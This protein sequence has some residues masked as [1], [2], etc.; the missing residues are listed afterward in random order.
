MNPGKG[1][2]SMPVKPIPDGYHS[3]TP[4]LHAKGVPRLIEFLKAAFGAIELMTVYH[5]DG[6]VMHAEVKIGDSIVMLDEAMEG[7][8][9][10]S[11]SFYLYV[12]DADATYRAA[13]DAGGES[14]M[15]PS[16]QFWGDRFSAIKDPA[17]NTW[18]VATHVEDVDAEELARRARARK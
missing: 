6:G 14:F 5:Q 15:E 16:D 13:L 1:G 2:I 4:F 10:S 8:S 17:G 3:I 18:F 11:G 12:P 7:V 9:P